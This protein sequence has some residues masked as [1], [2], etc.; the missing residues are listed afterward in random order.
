MHGCF[1]VWIPLSDFGSQ[2]LYHANSLG[3]PIE[4]LGLVG[5]SGIVK[6]NHASAVGCH[7][8]NRLPV[9]RCQ[10]RVGLHLVL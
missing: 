4:P 6:L 8:S 1:C 9:G 2:N 7:G 10:I 3:K 5:N